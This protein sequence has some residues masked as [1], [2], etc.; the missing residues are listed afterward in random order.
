MKVLMNNHHLIP[1][2]MQALP[3]I[4]QYEIIS[5]NYE[6]DIAI[7]GLQAFKALDLKEKELKKYFDFV[8]QPFEFEEIGQTFKGFYY[9][10]GVYLIM[11]KDLDN[12]SLSIYHRGSIKLSISL[13][14]SLN[15]F[16]FSYPKTLNDFL[17]YC[18][19]LNVELEF[20]E[21]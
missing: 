3:F 21:K 1:K 16:K 10:Q 17:T 12:V 8:S 4:K 2:N 15:E 5:K 14:N 9:N 13:S 7:G 18:S 20:A 11:I 6:K 19:V